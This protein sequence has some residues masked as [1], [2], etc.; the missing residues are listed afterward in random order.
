MQLLSKSEISNKKVEIKTEPFPETV[1]TITDQFTLVDA[2]M[3]IPIS[4]HNQIHIYV[5]E[6][7]DKQYLDIRNY[8][9]SNRMKVFQPTKQGVRLPLDQLPQLLIRLQ[10]L[11]ANG[12]RRNK[13]ELE[14]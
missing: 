7:Q 10:R 6:Y 4:P 8:H 1:L 11:N 2:V 13:F 5:Y 12:I 14:L 9:Y 3:Q